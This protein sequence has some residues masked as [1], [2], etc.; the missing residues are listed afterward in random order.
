MGQLCLRDSRCTARK[1][2]GVACVCCMIRSLIVL[3]DASNDMVWLRLVGSLNYRFILQI[4]VFFHRALLQKRRIIL[5]SLLIVATP[6]ACCVIPWGRCVLHE[7]TGLFCRTSSLF[8]GSFANETYHLCVA[9]FLEGDACCMIHFNWM[10]CVLCD[11][12]QLN[13]V[14]VAWR[15]QG[16]VFCIVHSECHDSFSSCDMCVAWFCVYHDW[17]VCVPWLICIPWLHRLCAVTH[18]VCVICVLYDSRCVRRHK[19]HTYKQIVC[20]MRVVR[21]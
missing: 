12:F 13:A 2:V 18:S 4:T 11:A 3:H 1:P 6:Y 10:M 19:W 15:I 8:Q 14:C 20:D 21:L 9:W 16:S 7:T 5:K 17:I